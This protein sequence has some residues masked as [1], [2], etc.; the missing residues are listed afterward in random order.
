[1]LSFLGPRKLPW[2]RNEYLECVDSF[3]S[4]TAARCSSNALFSYSIYSAKWHKQLPAT[5]EVF[6]SLW[7]R[8]Q[9]T[10]M[11]TNEDEPQQSLWALHGM[12]HGQQHRCHPSLSPHPSNG[13]RRGPGC[14]EQSHLTWE[15]NR[16]GGW[17]R[18]G[19]FLLPERDGIFIGV[20]DQRC[21]P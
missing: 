17:Q 16:T 12:L 19:A 13:A 15:D 9:P 3:I 18:S 11:G 10:A 21:S 8:R 5:A 20:L 2:K 14:A 7:W 1:M 4:F 6:F